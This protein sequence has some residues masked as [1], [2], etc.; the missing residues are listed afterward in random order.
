MSPTLK[1]PADAFA[2]DAFAAGAV[3]D[4]FPTAA[5]DSRS[6]PDTASEPIL[7]SNAFE[8]LARAVA[9]FHK[10]RQPDHSEPDMQQSDSNVDESLQ[11]PLSDLARSVRN[12]RAGVAQAVWTWL[13]GR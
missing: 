11:K 10:R 6:A 5:R 4:P 9:A 2:A 1:R 3:A 7:E 13:R 8:R 12:E